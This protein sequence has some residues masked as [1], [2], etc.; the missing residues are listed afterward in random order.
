[1]YYIAYYTLPNDERI[2]SPAA[3]AKIPVIA[4]AFTKCGQKVNVISSCTVTTD[5]AKGYVK[6][7]RFNI[8]KDVECTQFATFAT[9]KGFLRRLLYWRANIKLFFK[10]LKV[11]KG[12]PVCFYHA[13]ERIPVI[14][15]AKKIKKFK[16]ILEVEEIYA[17]AS[18]LSKKAIKNEKEMGE[19]TKSIKNKDP[20]NC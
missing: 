6:G 11:K 15:L 16:L 18:N 14:K 8:D 10:L 9:K 20:L 4:K 2:S 12:Q 7:R 1:M 13:I 19:G 5:N 17:N 3:N